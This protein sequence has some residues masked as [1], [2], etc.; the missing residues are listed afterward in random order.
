MQYVFPKDLYTDVRIEHLFSTNISYNLGELNECKERQYSAAFIRV[1]DGNRW[2]YTSTSDLNTIQTKIDALAK[3]AAPDVALEKTQ[4]F[5]NFS[6]EKG[7]RLIFTGEEVSKVPL[8]DKLS[9]LQSIKP[10]IEQHTIIKFYMLM[11]VDEYKVKEFYN[12]KGAESTWDFQRA[13]F[14][15]VLQMAEADRQM[16]DVFQLGETRFDALCGYEEKLT[17]LIKECEAFLHEAEAVEPGVYTVVLAPL[18][19][20]VF[21]HEC[22]GH[23]SESDF[24]MGDEATKAEWTIG[25]RLGSDELSIVESGQV[26]GLGYVPFDDEGNVATK[27]YLIKNGVLTG[28]LHNAASAAYLGE[29]VTGNARALNYEYEPI[30]RMTTTFID[31]G[32][33]TFERLIS[34]VENGIYIKGVHHG[35]G[36]STFTL[37]P[38]R[39]YYIKYGKIGKP[40]NISVVS[41]N[42][43]ESLSKVD[44]IANDMELLSIAIGGCG[45]MEQ[46]GLPIG[47]GGPHIRIRDM[48]VQ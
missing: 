47:M 10:L 44:G 48:Q 34:E 14:G 32:A 16:Q 26:F 23:K 37:A 4:I 7:E 31:N 15:V 19:S 2:Y 38:S 33:S 29:A 45:K 21:A 3:L 46:T 28:R 42:V 1:Y 20:G 30:V 17:E 12:S 24:M 35:F 5:K 36:M 6:A 22:F 11:Y 41:G 18:V 25:K 40:V 8:Y 9:F 27:T 13:G 39:A 43:F